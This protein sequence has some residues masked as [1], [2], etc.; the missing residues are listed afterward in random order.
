MLV[1]QARSWRTSSLCGWATL[2]VGNR[3]PLHQNIKLALVSLASRYSNDD[4][5]RVDSCSEASYQ[6]R[7]A[8]IPCFVWVSV[9]CVRFAQLIVCRRPPHK[10][11]LSS[12]RYFC[13]RVLQY[14][15]AMVLQVLAVVN[16]DDLLSV[17]LDGQLLDSSDAPLSHVRLL[18]A[19]WWKYIL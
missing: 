11:Q 2:M 4:L 8:G 6:P 5:Q 3:Y 18:A 19:S 7:L 13:N 17:W 10:L 12:C 16:T 1:L 9:P 14:T 15:T